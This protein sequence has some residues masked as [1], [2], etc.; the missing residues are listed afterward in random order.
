MSKAHL[1]SVVAI[2]ALQRPSSHIF[3]SRFPCHISR[4]RRRS[5]SP[6]ESWGRPSTLEPDIGLHEQEKNGG[7]TTAAIST[8]EVIFISI[9]GSN[10]T[11]SPAINDFVASQDLLSHTVETLALRLYLYKRSLTISLIFLSTMVLARI[12]LPINEGSWSQP[13]DCGKSQPLFTFF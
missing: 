7:I 2:L 10:P 1:L 12:T 5:H 8:Q 3:K 13:K 4:K 11:S 6:Q 9:Q